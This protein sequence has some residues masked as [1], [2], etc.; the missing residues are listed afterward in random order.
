MAS[1]ESPDST[2]AGIHR[3]VLALFVWV[4]FIWG[5]SLMPGGVSSEESLSCVNDMRGFFGL[6]GV[7][8]TLTMTFIVRKTAH[9]LE[10]TVLGVIAS[11]LLRRGWGSGR[12]HGRLALVVAAIVPVVDETIQLFVPGREGQVRDVCIDLLGIALGLLLARA[13]AHRHRSHGSD[14]AAR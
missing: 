10:Y 7:T 11:G 2:R 6:L 13:V 5:H 1:C 9:L 14:A 3:W 12:L 4:A 8:E